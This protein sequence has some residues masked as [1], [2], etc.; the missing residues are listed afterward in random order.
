MLLSG[1]AHWGNLQ[2]VQRL[3]NYGFDIHAQDDQALINAASGGYLNVVK[4]LISKGTDIHAQNDAALKIA[5]YNRRVPV[6]K[7]LLQ[8]GAGLRFLSLED[9]RRYQHL[10]PQSM[11]R[12]KYY[13]MESQITQI[14]EVSGKTIISIGNTTYI[15]SD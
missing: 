11:N 14:E 9:Q 2:E 8:H 12:R 13:L 5:I 4:F 15:L 10:V 7:F 6:M 3:V 1:A